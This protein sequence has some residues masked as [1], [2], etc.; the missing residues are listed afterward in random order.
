MVSDQFADPLRGQYRSAT[1]YSASELNT[2][3]HIDKSVS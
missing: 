2:E 3:T 1:A